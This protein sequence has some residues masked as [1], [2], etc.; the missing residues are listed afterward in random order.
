[1]ATSP[2]HQTT[3]VCLQADSMQA[4]CSKEKVSCNLQSWLK[5]QLSSCRE[6]CCR[7]GSHRFVVCFQESDECLLMARIS[8]PLSPKCHVFFASSHDFSHQVVGEEVAPAGGFV[9]ISAD[10]I[11]VMVNMGFL[12]VA[13][14]MGP[15]WSCWQRKLAPGVL[16][17]DLT[18]WHGCSY[19]HQ[20]RSYQ[21]RRRTTC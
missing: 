6:S 11:V 19:L 4:T 5:I 16:W 18:R 9:M 3:L 1:M 8:T 20:D 17:A 10:S 12:M 21:I 14:K 13:A 2:A 15:G 7:T